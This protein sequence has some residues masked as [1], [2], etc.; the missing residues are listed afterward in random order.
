[1]EVKAVHDGL[2]PSER[3][4]VWGGREGGREKG[5]EG[6]REGGRG[7]AP[8]IMCLGRTR[9]TSSANSLWSI[10]NTSKQPS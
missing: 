8:I 10:L 7:Y 3:M 4:S 9:R 6:R 1:M 2:R 5:R